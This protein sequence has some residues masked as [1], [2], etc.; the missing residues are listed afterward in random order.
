MRLEK[1][2][3]LTESE[4]LALDEALMD[5][6]SPALLSSASPGISNTELGTADQRLIQGSKSER[7][8]SNQYAEGGALAQYER[9]KERERVGEPLQTE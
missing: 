5:S 7:G 2:R 8:T 3:Q 9:E 1:D 4:E 6:S